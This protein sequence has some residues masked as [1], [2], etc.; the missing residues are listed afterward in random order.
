[1]QREIR[2]ILVAFID[3]GHGWTS[4]SASQWVDLISSDHAYAEKCDLVNGWNLFATRYVRPDCLPCCN[5]WVEL[6]SK[7]PKWAHR[8]D[9]YNGWKEFN[10]Y[11]WL[12]ILRHQ[13]AFSVKCEA[14]GGWRLF[15]GRDWV[16]LLICQPALA[17]YC[18]AKR[19]W[20]KIDERMRRVQEIV[21]APLEEEEYEEK[22]IDTTRDACARWVSLLSAQP[23]FAIKCDE[24]SVWDC[25]NGLNWVQLLMARPCFA[26]ACSKY[27]GW[28]K[29][30]TDYIESLVREKI[31]ESQREERSRMI[32]SEDI[33]Y[34]DE[35]FRN[36]EDAVSFCDRGWLG[37]FTKHPD[38][39]EA[40]IEQ[41]DKKFWQHFIRDCPRLAAIECSKMNLWHSFE[42]EDWDSILKREHVQGNLTKWLGRIA[43][44]SS[45]DFWMVLSNYHPEVL[46]GLS[47]NDWLNLINKNHDLAEICVVLGYANKFNWLSKQD[48]INEAEES[49]KREEMIKRELEEKKEE[50]FYK[51]IRKVDWREESGWNDVYGA[52][53]EASDIIEFR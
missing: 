23:Q 35:F 48:A 3:K 43:K 41:L 52:G 49:I 39:A 24:Y 34:E 1:M 33:Y 14:F 29:I 19:G 16:N 22:E 42:A 32:F 6:L 31:E 50:D 12:T 30:H 2:D 46:S 4:L 15:D 5:Y 47:M 18:E 10:S 28:N 36:K 40:N 45:K 9:E 37:L 11:D 7:H 27:S 53:V 8:C 13:P 20:D 26:S 21:S 51:D 44:E 38:F 25:L 17:K